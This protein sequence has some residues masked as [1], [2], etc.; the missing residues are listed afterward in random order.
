LLKCKFRHRI[1]PM[2]QRVPCPASP[3][4]CRRLVAATLRIAHVMQ[5]EF[6]SERRPLATSRWNYSTHD[7]AGWSV[8]AFLKTDHQLHQAR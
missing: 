8:P 2:P 3:N 7:Q 4:D 6:W 1:P 5:D